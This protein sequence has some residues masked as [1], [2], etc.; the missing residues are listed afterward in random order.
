M[1]NLEPDEPCRHKHIGGKGR[2]S[3]YHDESVILRVEAA[4]NHDE[5]EINFAR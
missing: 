5:S 3:F 1:S 4:S 2:S